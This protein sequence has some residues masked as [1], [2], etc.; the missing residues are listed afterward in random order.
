MKTKNQSV[1]N[2]A[3]F[4]LV[5]LLIAM[6]VALI[7][8]AAI[9]ASYKV[10]Q[11]SEKA[12]RQVT[13]IQQNLRAAMD[14]ISREFKIAGY[15]PSYTGNYGPLRTYSYNG[16]TYTNGSTTFIFTGDLCEEEDDPND[17]NSPAISCQASSPHAGDPLTETYVYRHYDSDGDGY[18]DSITRIPDVPGSSPAIIAENIE[19]LDFLYI[20]DSGGQQSS[21]TANTIDEVRAVRVSILARASEPDF[22]YTDSNVYP[23]GNGMD[24]DP[25]TF[26][27]A[28]CDNHDCLNYRRR[29]LVS[30]IELRN[31]GI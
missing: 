14:M 19:K 15:D 24:W 27:A 31:L 23:Y 25:S 16:N 1:Q 10:Q 3:G 21:L 9:Y 17:P 30:T 11:Q 4:T 6:V 13:E 26:D 7:V 5:E 8:S 2:A 22:K 12:Q 29:V 20:L 28:S 18:N